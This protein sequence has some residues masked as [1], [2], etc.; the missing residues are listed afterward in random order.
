MAAPTLSASHLITRPSLV[1]KDDRTSPSFLS[2]LWMLDLSSIVHSRSTTT[3]VAPC[4]SCSLH[5]S[6]QELHSLPEFELFSYLQF[7][8]DT[9]HVGV[10]D[11]IGYGGI[12][13]IHHSR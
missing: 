12:T 6:L 13:P 7:G 9:A 1:I 5:L 4:S 11:L 10:G 8:G 2:S 3:T